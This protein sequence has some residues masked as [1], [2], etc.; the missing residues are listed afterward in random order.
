MIGSARDVLL[1][2]VVLHG[3]RQSLRGRRPDV[4]ATATYIASRTMA[5]ELMVI[6][7]D[8]RSSGIPSNSSAMSS[9]ESMATPTRPTSPAASTV[10]G[11]VAHLGGQIERHAESRDPVLEQLPDTARFDSVAVPKPAYWRI[12]HRRPRYIVGWMPRVKG[13]LA[14][15]AQIASWIP[16]SRSD[17]TREESSI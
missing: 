8:T 4:S 11:V 12:V 2:D 10:I 16:V 9:M 6:D 17:G 5:V 1:E 15:P 3:S 13:R 14:R 7:V